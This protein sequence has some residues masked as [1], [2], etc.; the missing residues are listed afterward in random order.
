[1]TVYIVKSLIHM[2][3]NEIGLECEFWLVDENGNIMEAPAYNF[4]ADEMGFLIEL[5]SEWSSESDYVVET[6]E[7]DLLHAKAKA[8]SLGFRVEKRSLK[9][10]TE[11]WQDYIAKKYR[12]H[13]MED[14]TRNIYKDQK[15][16]QHTGFREIPGIGPVATAGLHVHFSKWDTEA[17]D[18]MWMPEDEIR[19]IVF[20]MDKIFEKYINEA[21]R[22]PGEWEPKGIGDNSKRPHGFE[23]RSLP[24]TAPWFDVAEA[25]LAVLRSV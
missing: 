21:H 3:L 16:T 4:P 19:A 20:A 23:Y 10:V 1:M 5:R 18:F 13:T 8:S 2:I 25:A 22:I 6:L 24:S 12:H 9:V 11:E 14:H 17:E 7:A 15:V